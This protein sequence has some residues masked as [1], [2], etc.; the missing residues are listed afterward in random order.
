MVDFEKAADTLIISFP[1]PIATDYW[2]MVDGLIA[3]K[4][5]LADYRGLCFLKG[6]SGITGNLEETLSL[7]KKIA[8]SRPYKSIICY[9]K[10]AGGY[11]AMLVGWL[12]KADYVIALSPPTC[13]NDALLHYLG[14]QRFGHDLGKLLED[15]D[16]AYLDIGTL[17]SAYPNIHTEVRV[18]Y[19]DPAAIDKSQ[20]LHLTNRKNIRAS[21]Y[22]V[23]EKLLA[24]GHS[25]GDA[26]NAEAFLAF[27]SVLDEPYEFVDN[28]AFPLC[29]ETQQQI[30][31]SLNLAAWLFNHFRNSRFRV[32]MGD[33]KL[34]VGAA[35]S[36][37]YPD[38]FVT[39]AEA[40]Q[41][42]DFLEEALLAVEVLNG[43]AMAFAKGRRFRLFA[44]VPILCEY[45]TIDAQNQQVRIWRREGSR[46][47]E[48]GPSSPP[49]ELNL[50][51]LG[52]AIPA[53]V[54]FAN[55]S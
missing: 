42:R 6:F 32:H 38:L 31:I 55:L 37:L 54:L 13:F 20:I 39:R 14:D 4:L 3:H 25:E 53:T 48:Y 1:D 35:R 5:I 24:V 19:N 47:D 44:M 11:L 30:T 9:G 7:I 2:R 36:F 29:T 34:L 16:P 22:D 45:V 41:S 51:S 10:S 50:E 46:W 27:C 8:S 52:V 12:I 40:P 26:I 15:I 17:F 49:A 33:K 28:E 18:F 21:T 43:T 23:Y